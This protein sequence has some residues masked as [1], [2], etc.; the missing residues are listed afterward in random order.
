M[1]WHAFSYNGSFPPDRDAKDPSVPV[2]PL[3]LRDWFRKPGSLRRGTHPA[4]E[5]A[6][7]WLEAELTELYHDRAQLASA[8][9]HHRTN[10]ELGQDAYV[11][12][13]SAGGSSVWVRALLTCPRTGADIRPVQ[14]PE[15]PRGR[16]QEKAP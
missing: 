14:C 13:Y 1:H 3:A 7:A 16:T 15:P 12:H 6:Y 9:A 8:L 2:R 10:L 5:G 11:S 4:A